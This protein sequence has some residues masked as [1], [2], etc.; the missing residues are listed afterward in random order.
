VLLAIRDDKLV[1]CLAPQ[2]H[3]GCDIQATAHQ[4]VA[5]AIDLARWRIS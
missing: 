1:P 2:T 4:N 3:N 5:A